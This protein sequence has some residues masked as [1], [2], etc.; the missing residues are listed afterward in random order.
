[1]RVVGLVSSGAWRWVW[2]LTVCVKEL[3]WVVAVDSDVGVQSDHFPAPF[4]VQ[5]PPS[6]SSCPRGRQVGGG[7]ESIP[8]A[9]HIWVRKH[10]LQPRLCPK[11]VGKPGVVD[12]EAVVYTHGVAALG[13]ARGGGQGQLP[14][15][16]DVVAAERAGE[17][18]PEDHDLVLDE[19]LGR[20]VDNGEGGPERRPGGGCCR[21]SWGCCC[22]WR[23]GGRGR[24]GALVLGHAG[25]CCL[26]V[27][28]TLYSDGC[29]FDVRPQ[30]LFLDKSVSV[31]NRFGRALWTDHRG[32]VAAGDEKEV[33]HTETAQ[34]FP[35]H[36]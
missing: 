5:R 20:E 29:G 14:E 30:S 4:E 35:C 28:C 36:V 9:S 18:G 6:A 2:A 1:M 23:V 34:Y 25:M 27:F 13:F 31:S 32:G 21:G 3:P 22:G 7:G 33:G 8:Q 24:L 16:G 12:L 10:I 19:V 11:A 15:E 26:S 17:E